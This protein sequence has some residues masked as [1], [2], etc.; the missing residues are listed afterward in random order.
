MAIV[1]GIEWFDRM[2]QQ[3]EDILCEQ[4]FLVLNKDGDM[5][6]DRDLRNEVEIDSAGLFMLFVSFQA[7]LCAAQGDLKRKDLWDDE[8]VQQAWMQC[9][10]WLEHALECFAWT[11]ETHDWQTICVRLT[12][13]VEEFGDLVEALIVS[14]SLEARANQDLEQFELARESHLETLVHRIFMTMIRIE[15]RLCLLRRTEHITDDNAFIHGMTMR[16]RLEEKVFGKFNV[17]LK[18]WRVRTRF[19]L[20]RTMC[21][22]DA[23][24]A[25]RRWCGLFDF[26]G[27][28]DGDA[29]MP[30]TEEER[31]R[32]RVRFLKE[33]ENL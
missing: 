7:E 29:V 25:M 3:V 21:H 9:D 8:T 31:E 2:R 6:V 10:I 30:L 27:A 15:R 11:E 16:L 4:T 13:E 22:G 5:V 24:W 20:L 17:L 33:A 23:Q 12:Q 14:A 28:F 32:I 19:N 1:T 18:S 26:W